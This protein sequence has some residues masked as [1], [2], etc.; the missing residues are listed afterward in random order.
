VKASHH[1]R[2]VLIAGAV[3]LW[4]FGGS[5]IRCA[6]AMEPLTLARHRDWLVIRGLHLPDGEI[7][8]HYLEA[9]CRAGSTDADWVK[10]TVIPHRSELLSTSA[11]GQQM[12]L[13]DTLEDG[14]VVEHTITV[15]GDHVDFRAHR[16]EFDQ[17]SIPGA[18]GA[19]VRAARRLHRFWTKQH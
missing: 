18:L 15:D 8:I 10:H 3:F 12:K 17:H 13:R 4:F 7:R 14:L 6:S 16:A 11:D 5:S 19:A 1:F 9:Y 2:S